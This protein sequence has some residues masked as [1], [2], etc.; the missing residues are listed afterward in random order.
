VDNNI[1]NQNFNFMVYPNPISDELTIKLSE[2]NIQE[3]FQLIITDIV[4]REVRN[5]VISTNISTLDVN[6]IQR[7]VYICT[8]IGNGKAVS[9][10]II[11][12]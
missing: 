11:K 9:Q 3:P 5:Y 8:V 2:S 4:G 12:L 6:N 1:G 10:K 7:G